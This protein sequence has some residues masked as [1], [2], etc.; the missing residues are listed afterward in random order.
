[1]NAM[2]NFPNCS[3]VLIGMPGGGKT[4]AGRELATLLRRRFSDT[5]KLA[6]KAAGMS[7]AD[8]FSQRG[9]DDFR[10]LESAALR[11]ALQE[12][13]Q[14]I[15]AGGG[16][17][18]HKNNRE[19]IRK[20]SLAV[21]LCAP[22]QLLIRRLQNDKTERPLLAGDDSAAILSDLLAKREPLYRKISRLAIM[23]SERDSPADVAAKTAVALRA[24]PN[25]DAK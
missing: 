1:M 20:F 4:S 25:G 19:L 5:D 14:I 24:L 16:V 21:Y 9:E 13:P 8:I 2:N 15:A 22:M 7:V 12:P 17:V 3:I 23:Q 6:E 18:L 10:K 11:E